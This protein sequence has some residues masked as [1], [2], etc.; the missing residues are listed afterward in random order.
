MAG[1][2]LRLRGTAI[3]G[4]NATTVAARAVGRPKTLHPKQMPSPQSTQV[5]WLQ[6]AQAIARAVERLHL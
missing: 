6:R 4:G 5:D 2:G 3:P 1:N